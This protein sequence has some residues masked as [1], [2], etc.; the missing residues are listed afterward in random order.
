VWRAWPPTVVS[1]WG[2]ISDE[3]TGLSIINRLVFNFQRIIC[4][5]FKKFRI[6]KT[7]FA[8]CTLWTRSPFSPGFGKQNIPKGIT[9]RVVWKLEASLF[10]EVQN[11]WVTSNIFA[12]FDTSLLSSVI[13]CC[14]TAATLHMSSTQKLFIPGTW[15]DW[16]E[17]VRFTLLLCGMVCDTRPFH[18]RRGAGTTVL[19][20][21]VST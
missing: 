11:N 4:T 17:M 16:R 1:S 14:T 5:S 20:Y 10:R 7:P 13:V 19:S 2:A 12:C 18:L 9:L 21:S 3:R 6:Y 15:T 8:N